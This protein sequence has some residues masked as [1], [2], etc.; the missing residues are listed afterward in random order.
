MTTT[1]RIGKVG[2]ERKKKRR[3][4]G[5]SWIIH[6]LPWIIIEVGNLIHLLAL[7]Y[8]CL[9]LFFRVADG[10]KHSCGVGN[11]AKLYY[12]YINCRANTMSK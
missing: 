6:N 1:V 9:A 5:P 4:F 12:V 2:K 8:F 10:Q 7:F 11:R 3:I